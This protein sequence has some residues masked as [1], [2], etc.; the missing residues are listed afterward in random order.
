[1]LDMLHQRDSAYRGASKVNILA[2]AVYFGQVS[3]YLSIFFRETAESIKVKFH[4][5]YSLYEKT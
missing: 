4:V 1:M 5:E 2:K 3:M